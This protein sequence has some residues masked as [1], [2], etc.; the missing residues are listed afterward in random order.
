MRVEW[1]DGFALARSSNTTPVV[2]LR[3][4]GDSKA[5]LERIR[6]RFTQEM[7]RIEPSLAIPE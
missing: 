3:F 1:A 2:V 5:S 6:T 7:R 4:E